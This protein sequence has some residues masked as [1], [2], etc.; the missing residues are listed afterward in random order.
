MFSS[1]VIFFIRHAYN[2]NIDEVNVLVIRGLLE[3]PDT[4]KLEGTPLQRLKCIFS[5]LIGVVR[6]YIKS[7]DSQLNCLSG[8]EYHCIAST[9]KNQSFNPTLLTAIISFLYDSDILDEEVIKKWHAYPSSIPSLLS[10]DISISDDQQLKL[11]EQPV[12]VK[13]ISWLDEAEEE[14]SDDD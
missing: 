6:N 10:D 5:S 14:S 11:R 12:L 3:L 8:L 9:A 4:L 2:I 13:F 1:F 7:S